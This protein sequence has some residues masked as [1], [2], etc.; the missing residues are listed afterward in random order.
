VG[1]EGAGALAAGA[2]VG[3]DAA[4]A[5]AG[6]SGDETTFAVSGRTPEQ[7]G[8]ARSTAAVIRVLAGCFMSGKCIAKRSSPPVPLSHR[9]PEKTPGRGGT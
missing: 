2:A 1:A 9:P 6:L 4:G 8:R 3:A 7:A 5:A